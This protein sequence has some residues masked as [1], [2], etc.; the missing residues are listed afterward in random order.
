M[1]T[2]GYLA[3]VIDQEATVVVSIRLHEHQQ[4]LHSTPCCYRN[5]KG[6]GAGKLEWRHCPTAVSAG[7]H[8]DHKH[9]TVLL[10][11]NCLRGHRGLSVAWPP[12]RHASIVGARHKQAR[13]GAGKSRHRA[14]GWAAISQHKQGS[15]GGAGGH[16]PNAHSSVSAAD[17]QCLVLRSREEGAGRAMAAVSRSTAM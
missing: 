1:C 13:G 17:R 4:Y 16:L 7:L 11:T 9:T 3:Y 10:G 2:F 14:R 5:M 12:H 6:L 8:K 15:L